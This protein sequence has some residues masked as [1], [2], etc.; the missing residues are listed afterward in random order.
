MYSHEDEKIFLEQEVLCTG[1]VENWLNVLLKIHQQ[2]VG[3]VI[4]QGLQLLSHPDTVI[5][6]LIDESIL[7]V[8]IF[9]KF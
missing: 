4:S 9:E 2:S 7:Q 3:A 1:G 8:F 6:T 5:L